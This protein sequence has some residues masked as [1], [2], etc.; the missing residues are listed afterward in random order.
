LKL[1]V[2]LRE[3]CQADIQPF[4]DKIAAVSREHWTKWDFRQTEY[5]VHSQTYSIPYFWLHNGVSFDSIDQMEIHEQHIS[6]DELVDPLLAKIPG[7]VVKLALVNLPAGHTIPEHVDGSSSLELVHRC[8]LP[9]VSNPEVQFGIE[10]EVFY[11]QPGIWYEFDNTRRHFVAN[12][13]TQ[14]RVHL[15][16]DIYNDGK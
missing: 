4:A 3:V 2:K 13:S 16:C 14:D 15:L 8:H 7:T 12:N 6:V 5:A 11:M 9:I 10:G 1:D